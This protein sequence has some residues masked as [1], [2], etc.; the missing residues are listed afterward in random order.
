MHLVFGIVFGFVLAR[1]GATDFDAIAGMF[2]LRDLHLAGVIAVAVLVAAPAFWWLRRR[3]VAGPSGCRITLAPKPQKPGLVA[4]SLLFGAGWGL[5]GTC[6]GTALAQL[7]EGRWVA[8]ATIAGILGGAALYRALGARVERAL[9]RPARPQRISVEQLAKDLASAEAPL[10]LDVRE[11]HELQGEL[12]R[13]PDARSIPL[14]ELPRR[15]S[16]LA[17]QERRTVVTICRSGV[18]SLTAAG[19]L[20]R[21]GFTAV[22]SLDGGMRRW[23]DLGLAVLRDDA[24]A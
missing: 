17:G 23:N 10:L 5:T 15:M 21:A 22:R 4:G 3:G 16:E 13:L 18:R 19:M 14:A 20:E 24:A 1:V 7:G 11:P 2:L 9:S 8:A 12:G 6:P